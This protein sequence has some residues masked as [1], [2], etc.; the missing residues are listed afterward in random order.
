MESVLEQRGAASISNESSINPNKVVIEILVKETQRKLCTVSVLES[1]T[2]AK[3]KQEI[4]KKNKRVVVKNLFIQEEQCLPR[5]IKLYN[6]ENE[7]DGPDTVKLSKLGMSNGTT[8]SLTVRFVRALAFLS[9]QEMKD[10][11]QEVESRTQSKYPKELIIQAINMAPE[12][13]IDQTLSNLVNNAVR[14]FE[15]I[16]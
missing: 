9:E 11:V 7:I 6:G 2:M 13:K 3:V 12:C 14:V 4:L 8:V 15:S 16:L 1:E 10:M 5:I